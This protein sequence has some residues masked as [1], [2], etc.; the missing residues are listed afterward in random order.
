MK[1]LTLLFV[2]LLLSTSFAVELPLWEAGAMPGEATTEPEKIWHRTENNILCVTHVSKPTLSFYPAKNTE[3]PTPVVIV[4]PGGSYQILAYD[5]EGTE[6]VKWLNSIGVSA[7]LL[8][9]RVPNNRA[10]ALEDARRAIRMVRAHSKDW[11]IDPTR[12][13][14]LGFSAGGHLAT[15]CSNSP[16]RPDFTI[17]VYPAYLSEKG[18]IKLVSEIKI[19]S[20]T[21]PAFIVQARDDKKYYRSSLAYAV[22]LDTQD[23]PVELHL[24]AK[25]GHGFG[26]RSKHPISQWPKLCEAWMHEMKFL[27]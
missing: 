8:K 17:L 2:G 12:V 11:N 16:D 21:P 23:I 3:V 20:Q 14:M 15:S 22:A 19:D 6:V 5:L 25:G 26:L 13:G 7:A 9:Y 10:G 18:G 24:F 27:R 1:H 4:C